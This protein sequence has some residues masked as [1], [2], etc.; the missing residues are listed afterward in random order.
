MDTLSTRPAQPERADNEERAGNTS[1]GE[2]PHL[3]VARPRAIEALGAGQIPI[4]RQV[5][6]SG[7]EGA[8]AD[9]EEGEAC[10]AGVEVVDAGEDYGVG[11]QE[12]VEYGVF[13]DGG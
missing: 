10:F 5:D 13:G 3:F 6:A 4:P 2:P 12:Y 7:D 1:K 11:L 8:D 9:G